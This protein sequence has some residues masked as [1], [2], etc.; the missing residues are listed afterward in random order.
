MSDRLAEQ[1]PLVGV[2][3]FAWYRQDNGQWGNG[4]TAVPSDAPKPALG[5]YRSDDGA[6]MDAHIAGML[7]AGFD[8]VI[9][10]VDAQSPDSWASA[11][12]FM[13]RVE[14]TALKVAVMVDGLY[15]APMTE[16]SAAVEKARRE[17]ASHPNYLWL[18]G[19]PLL[20]LFSG[21]LDQEPPGVLLRNAYWA[22]RYEPGANTFNPDGLLLPHDWPFW[23]PTPQLLMNGV[24][25]V[26]PGYSDTHLERDT[27]MEHPRNNGQMYHEQW[28]RALALRPE[29]ILVYSWNEH[30]EQTAIEPTDA[31]GDQY[32]QWTACYVAHAHAGREGTC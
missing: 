21:R 30:F 27:A 10:Q 23:A 29:F 22:D 5:W 32:V 25:P 24:V 31:W 20:V 26:A 19:R 7:T 16:T 4:V 8:F 6:V 13:G 14:G 28:Q 15:T 9:V 3:Y 12:R 11:H 1:R 18:R 17:F 2:Y